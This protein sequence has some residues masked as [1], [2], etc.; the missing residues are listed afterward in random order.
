LLTATATC[1]ATHPRVIGGGVTSTNANAADNLHTYQVAES[2]APTP[3]SW[4]VTIVSF[5]NA[6]NVTLQVQ[7]ICIP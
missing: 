3:G 1:P 5:G 6:G 2:L 7:A 4:R